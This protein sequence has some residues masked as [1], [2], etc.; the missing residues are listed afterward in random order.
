MST[1]NATISWERKGVKFIDN[2][3]AR[4][5]LWQFD[6]VAKIPASS[7]PQVVPI[8]YSN[9]ASID[10]EEAFLASLSSCHMLWFLSI[11][12]KRGYVV[13]EYKDEAEAIMEK[14]NEGKLAITKV[15]LHPSVKYSGEATPL[16]EENSA[17]HHEANQ[18][19]FIANS[20]LTEVKIHPVIKI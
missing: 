12:A 15:F 9:P 13:D 14:N 10:P 8:P 16:V 20:V 3:Y 4:D 6:G 5:H 17:L 1:Y 19:C 2:K 7:S 11:A 18:K